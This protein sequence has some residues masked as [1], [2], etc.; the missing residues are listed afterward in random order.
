MSAY[1][2]TAGTAQGDSN[3]TL[4]FGG[5]F[6][7]PTVTYDEQG[8]ITGKGTT[9]MTMPAT[10]T[11][12]TGNAGSATKLATAR[13]IDG[14]SFDGRAA[15]THY[16]TCST[17]AS[18]AAK[19]V[20]LTSF[21]L[22]TGSKVM[23]KFTVTNTAASPTLNVNGTGAKAIMYRGTAISAGYLA[24]NRVYEFVYD[25]T[26]YELVGDINVDTNTDTKVTNTLATTTK[27]YITGT[28]SN[29]TNTG[30][31]VFDTGV[32]LDTT[33]GMLTATTFKGSLSGNAATATTATKANTL[34]TA[35]TIGA[36]GGIT[37]TATSFNGS[38]NIT[39]PVTA[40]NSDYFINGQNTLILNCGSATA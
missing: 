9:T 27:A 32:Y 19:V 13:T 15:I 3:K 8:H 36:S 31:Q 7:V 20:S 2:V 16:G 28:T 25:G 22:A 35:R 6:L 34:T 14:V 37:A 23:V 4:T 24:A 39:I 1:S 40:V 18:T 17:E 5:T 21:S 26:N 11:T 38:A 10:P 29:T 12:I 33:E 30:T